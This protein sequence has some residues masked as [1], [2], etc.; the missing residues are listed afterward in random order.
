MRSSNSQFPCAQN[1]KSDLALADKY[2][3]EISAAKNVFTA[4]VMQLKKEDVPVPGL[5]DGISLQLKS[6]GS[7]I[8]DCGKGT[9]REISG[10]S[11]WGNNCTWQV[12]RYKK[13]DVP[14]GDYTL[15]GN[16]PNFNPV[17]YNAD[18][19]APGIKISGDNGL[20]SFSA[21]TVPWR[22]V[23]LQCWSGRRYLMIS[24]GDAK[25]EGIGAAGENQDG[26]PLNWYEVRPGH[27]V[28][29]H[30]GYAYWRLGPFFLR[31][32]PNA[33]VRRPC[34]L[35]PDSYDAYL[36]RGQYD[37]S[38]QMLKD[39]LWQVYKPDPKNEIFKFQLT[40]FDYQSGRRFMTMNPTYQDHPS[41][42]KGILQVSDTGVCCLIPTGDLASWLIE[43]VTPWQ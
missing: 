14:A 29:S 20:G 28:F 42:I 16:Y 33:G 34:V 25:H 4:T 35:C 10:I 41:A 38:K 1:E 32:D 11:P 13:T 31:Q 6:A 18:T 30:P 23:K 8:V 5:K 17:V 7:Q 40:G 3:N 39:Y 21:Y 12:L 24:L 43:P 19:G 36:E 2:V 15:N 22:T 9:F 27:V 37:A 26:S